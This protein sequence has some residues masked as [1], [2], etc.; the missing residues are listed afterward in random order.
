VTI[1][2]ELRD[3]VNRTLHEV[4]QLE[5]DAESVEIRVSVDEENQT[6]VL[7]FLDPTI[8]PRKNIESLH[9][10]NTNELISFLRKPLDSLKCYESSSGKKYT[11]DPRT[12]VIYDEVYVETGELSTGFIKPLVHMKRFLERKYRVPKNAVKALSS[13]L[14]EELTLV[15][16]PDLDRY[17]QKQKKCWRIWFLNLPVGK[18]LKSIESEMWSIHDVALFYECEQLFD[19]DLDVRYPTKVLLNK[20]ET[21]KFPRYVFEYPRLSAFLRTK[22]LGKEIGTKIVEWPDSL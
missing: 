6:Y 10:A 14:G 12:D 3:T 1:P 7:Q 21:V 13:D 19:I 9:L 22:G 20:I 5:P 17:R 2:D 8:W 11:W 4:A 18:S 16:T 15:A